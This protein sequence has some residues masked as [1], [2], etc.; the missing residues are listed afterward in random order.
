VESLKSKKKFK[1][2]FIGEEHE[3][4]LSGG[5]LL[6]MLGAFR[7]AVEVNPNDNTV[8]W[9]GGFANVL[10]LWEETGRDLMEAT[11]ETSEEL[12]RNPNAI[13]KSKKHWAFLH[14]II[15]RHVD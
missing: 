7:A 10:H 11:Q 12:G 6:P 9:K 2:P 5:A 14:N 15:D 4:R 8:G 13:G 1:F 3:Y